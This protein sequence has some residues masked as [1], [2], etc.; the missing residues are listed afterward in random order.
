MIVILSPA[1]RMNFSPVVSPVPLTTPL[2]IAEAWL[3]A[4]KMK[5]Y[6]PGQLTRLLKINP[7]LALSTAERFASFQKEP[8]DIATKPAI[9]A[10][11]GDAYKGLD[12]GSSDTASLSFAQDH[13]RILSALYGILR[14]FDAIQPYRLEMGIVLR[15][16]HAANLYELWRNKITQALAS[17]LTKEQNPILVNLASIEYFSSIVPEDI[18][19]RTITPVFKEFRNGTYKILSMFAKFVRG[20]MAR[21]IM[22]NKITNPEDI[23]LFDLEGYAYDANLSG[24]NR[25][26]F[27]R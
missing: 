18:E 8:L 9:F 11:K 14:P 15:V 25:W 23:K 5:E 27:T 13:L 26:I 10:Y 21:F 12:P 22:K 7:D 1:K 3:I 2:F 6:S 20:R 4:E 19:A 17:E 24:E 16:N